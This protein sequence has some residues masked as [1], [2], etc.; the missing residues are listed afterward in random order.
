[1][2]KAAS[3]EEQM[4][5]ARRQAEAGTPVAE[6]CRT[7]GVSEQTFSRWKRTYAGMGVSELRRLRLLEEENRKPKQLV[8]DL[9]L[10]KHRL[11]EVIRKKL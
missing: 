3:S 11:Q 2:K 5:Y 4:A 1:V 7:L 8:A 10:D 9:T 6:V